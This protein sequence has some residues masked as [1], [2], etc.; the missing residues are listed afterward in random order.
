MSK[1]S[2]FPRNNHG[3]SDDKEWRKGHATSFSLSDGEITDEDDSD[4]EY[5]TDPEDRLSLKNEDLDGGKDHVGYFGE[6]DG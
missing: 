3:Q 4:S 1:E 6:T 2:G 5:D